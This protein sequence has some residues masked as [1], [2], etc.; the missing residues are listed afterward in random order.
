MQRINEIKKM[1]FKKINRIYRMLVRLTNKKV[2]ISTIKNDEGDT[3]TDNIEIWKT[4]E[5]P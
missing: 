5:R 4:L 2:Q 3:T 1:F